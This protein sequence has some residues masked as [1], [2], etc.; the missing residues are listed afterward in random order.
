MNL[1]LIIT[2]ILLP[3]SI[4][5]NES[6]NLVANRQKGLSSSSCKTSTD[7]YRKNR[8]KKMVVH[9]CPFE[10]C[11]YQTTN[12]KMV[13]T[14]HINSCHVEEKDRPFQCMHCT[15][16]FAQK[17][18]LNKHLKSVHQIK[19]SESKIAYILYIISVTDTL[20]TSKK[21]KAR[22]EYYQKN[23]NLKSKDIFNKKH[24]YL[25]GCFLKNHDLHYDRRKGFITLNKVELKS[26]VNPIKI[27]HPK[28]VKTLNFNTCI[29]IKNPYNQ[30]RQDEIGD[31]ISL[32][33]SKRRGR[34]CY[35]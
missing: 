10:G 7:Y 23:K 15:R 16:G 27:K 31:K 17:S 22:R 5:P 30:D 11:D 25:E 4:C 20:P 6:I 19:P 9:K 32:N 13:L 3:M 18:H 35:S 8:E 21:T 29:K 12:C 26:P 24:E 1:F 34:Y 33:K 2:D 14:N 28:F